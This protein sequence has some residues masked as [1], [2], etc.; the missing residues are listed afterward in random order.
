[1]P[2]QRARCALLGLAVLRLA[3]GSLLLQTL[4]S[5]VRHNAYTDLEGGESGILQGKLAA[6]GGEQESLQVLVRAPSGR[7]TTAVVRLAGTPLVRV[8]RLGFVWASNA[9]DPLRVW[10]MPCPA[11]QLLRGGCW[12]ADPILSLDANGTLLLPAGFTVALWLTFAPPTVST[13][14]ARGQHAVGTQPAGTQPAHPRATRGQG[15]R[16]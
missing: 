13:A 14:P 8:E 6:A 7:N 10:P 5:S 3:R 16:P 2:P 12:V 1:M 9:T 4:P 11:S 15:A